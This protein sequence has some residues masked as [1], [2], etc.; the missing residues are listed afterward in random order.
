[1]GLAHI[2]KISCIILKYGFLCL[3]NI[4]FVY[5]KIITIVVQVTHKMKAMVTNNKTDNLLLINNCII[6]NKYDDQKRDRGR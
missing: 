5:H 3:I 1:M 6:R 4:V 2:L